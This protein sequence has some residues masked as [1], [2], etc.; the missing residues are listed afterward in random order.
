MNQVLEPEVTRYNHPTNKLSKEVK[1][2]TYQSEETQDR[3]SFGLY[4]LC[5]GTESVSRVK[6]KLFNLSRVKTAEVKSKMKSK[7]I[8]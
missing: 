4:L 3:R 8:N 2:E 5:L 6:Q 1:Q 7:N